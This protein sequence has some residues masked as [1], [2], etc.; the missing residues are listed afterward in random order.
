LN[1]DLVLQQGGWRAALAAYNAG[2]AGIMGIWPAST[3]KYVNDIESSL[4]P[5]QIRELDRLYG[6]RSQ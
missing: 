2:P 5:E 3:K 4:E 1:N 6:G